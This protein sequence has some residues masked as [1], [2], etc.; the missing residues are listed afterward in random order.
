M[1]VSRLSFT[2]IDFFCIFAEFYQLFAVAVIV[3]ASH[4]SVDR[5]TGLTVGMTR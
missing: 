5:K 4:D 3:H 2:L 1:K